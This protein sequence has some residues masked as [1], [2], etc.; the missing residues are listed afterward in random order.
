MSNKLEQYLY[1]LVVTTSTDLPEDVETAIAKGLEQE[2]PGSAAAAALKAIN[3]NIRLA[4]ERK[5]P[6]CQDTGTII[7]HVTVPEN[8]AF[9]RRNFKV[10]AES[11]VVRATADGILRQNSVC[12]LTGKN[13]GNNLGPGAPVIHYHEGGENDINVALMLKGGGSENVGMQYS[14]PDKTIDA[15]RDID[16]IKKCVIDAVVKAQGKGC[17]PGILSVVVGGDRATG[18]EYSK[19][20]LLRKIGSRSSNPELAE[21]EDEM[22]TKANELGIGP[23]GLGGKTTLLDVF[24]DAKNRVPASYFVSI[25][26]MCWA[27]RRRDTSIPLADLDN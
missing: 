6:L 24:I 21:L 2:E 22:L 26:Y 18:Y 8:F 5:Q 14:L 25:S 9:S 13:S 20:Q 12:P 3:D 17:A 7:F 27:F 11:A 4:R 15:G 16:G 23:M 1:D 19:E 10:A